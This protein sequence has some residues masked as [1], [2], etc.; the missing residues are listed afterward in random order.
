MFGGAIRS[1]VEYPFQCNEGFFPLSTNCSRSSGRKK[2]R[3][4]KSGSADDASLFCSSFSPLS[5]P[6]PLVLYSLYPP[7]RRA[8]KSPS[9]LPWRWT[10][11]RSMRACRYV[12][13]V[14]FS[15]S[16]SS[17]PFPSPSPLLSFPS[18]QRSTPSSKR[19][20]LLPLPL[21]PPKLAASLLLHAVEAINALSAVV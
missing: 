17:S 2:N 11:K 21:S 4:K 19:N 18:R 6:L 5:A 12:F 8:P 13:F 9:P 15:C 20:L 3:K 14:A 1:R 16:S 7:Q 10:R